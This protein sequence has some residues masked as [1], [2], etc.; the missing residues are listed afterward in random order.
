VVRLPSS[1]FSATISLVTNGDRGC[2]HANQLLT[3][4]SIAA[5]GSALNA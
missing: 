4:M 2:V 1:P 3:S 5:A